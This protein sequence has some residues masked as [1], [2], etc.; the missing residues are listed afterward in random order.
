[1]TTAA[2]STTPATIQPAYTDAER[3]ALAGSPR[4]PART[5]STWAW[6]AATGP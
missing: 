3:I 4:P 1:M 2:P 6:S 5:S